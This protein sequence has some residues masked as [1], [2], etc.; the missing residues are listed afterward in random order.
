MKHRLIHISVLQTSKVMAVLYAI[1][2]VIYIPLGMAADA[3]A[4]AEDRLG[5]IWLLVPLVLG[6]FSFVFV[7]LD[8]EGKPRP[9]PKEE[10]EA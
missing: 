1:F 4:P 10:V 5:L 3:V 6:A 9:V 8:A 7:A 2:G